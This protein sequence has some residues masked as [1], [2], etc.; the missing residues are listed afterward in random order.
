MNEILITGAVGLITT[1]V[2]WFLAKKK[3][4]V[5]VDGNVIENMQKSLDF[6]D[7]LSSDNKQRLEKAI[8]ENKEMRSEMDLLSK[9]NIE[10]KNSIE[11]LTK[12]NKTLKDSISTLTKENKDL[13]KGMEELKAQIAVLSKSISVS[14]NNTEPKTNKNEKGKSGKTVRKSSTSK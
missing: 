3:Y 13:K 9:E 11:A 14:S 7:K 5:E 8:E 6:Y 10:L 4:N 12:E 1:I 2:S